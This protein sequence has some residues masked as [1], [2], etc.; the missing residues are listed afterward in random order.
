MPF[1]DI[2][3]KHARRVGISPDWMKKIMRI[4]SGGDPKSVTGSYK[5]LFQLSDREFRDGGGSGNIH[6]PE[7]NT[8]AAANKLARESLEF[9]E[10][11]D[12]NPKL[13]DLYMIH[14]Q[15]PSGYAA[16]MKNPD[17]PAWENMASTGEGKQKGEAWAKRA[18]WGNM[19]AAAKAKYGSV[20]NVSS[21]DFIGE[22]GNRIE[23]TGTEWEPTGTSRD[24]AP[25]PRMARAGYG[26]DDAKTAFLEGK[27][28]KTFLGFAEEDEFKPRVSGL[29]VPNLVPHFTLGKV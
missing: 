1:N 4:E 11:Y 9:K 12:R 19:P 27:S 14:Q 10:K 6:D 16:H 29:T 7:Q 21:K 28:K 18:I 3:E 13:Q 15:G 17:A 22:W 2:I 24:R 20:E 25:G 26:E 5:G 8:A 23:G